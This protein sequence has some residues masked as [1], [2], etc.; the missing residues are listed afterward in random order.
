MLFN[1]HEYVRPTKLVQN[2]CIEFLI[3]NTKK[4]KSIVKGQ[5]TQK[6][7]FMWWRVLACVSI[8]SIAAAAKGRIGE[9][10][11]VQSLDSMHVQGYVFCCTHG[12]TVLACSDLRAIKFRSK[13]IPNN[14]K[15]YDCRP[16]RARDDLNSMLCAC[17]GLMAKPNRMD[18]ATRTPH[19]WT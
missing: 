1:I 7:A 18:D 13:N 5:D 10:L 19:A 9:R 11:S 4:Y 12:R 6:M 14:Q 2:R 16:S 15:I 3:E 8:E 17:S